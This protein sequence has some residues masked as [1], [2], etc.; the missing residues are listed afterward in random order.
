M[1]AART[2]QFWRLRHQRRR[3]AAFF[4]ALVVFIIVILVA[5]PSAQPPQAFT[6]SGPV[7]TAAI[8]DASSGPDIDLLVGRSTVLNVGCAD[9]A[10]V[11]DGG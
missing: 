2:T 3:P 10:S 4:A 6:P 9:R 5:A 8:R 7:I 1:I 11:A